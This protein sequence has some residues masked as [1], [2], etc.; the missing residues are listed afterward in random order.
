MLF[1]HEIWSWRLRLYT[2]FSFSLQIYARLGRTVSS[3][4]EV[5]QVVA[6]IGLISIS[7]IFKA[8]R[9]FPTQLYECSFLPS[10]ESSSASATINCGYNRGEL[11][12][13]N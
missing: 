2:I 4:D 3:S 6:C 12:C 8:N 7:Q 11:W 9:V 10:S 5:L 13:L 1:S